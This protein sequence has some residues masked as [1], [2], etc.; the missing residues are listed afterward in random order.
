MKKGPMDQREPSGQNGKSGPKEQRTPQSENKKKNQ[1]TSRK[2]PES[3][4]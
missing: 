3:R 2:D 1:P 4:F